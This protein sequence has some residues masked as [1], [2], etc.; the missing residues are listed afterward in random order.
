MLKMG[1][2]NTN[3]KN[4]DNKHTTKNTDPNQNHSHVV[5]STSTQLDKQTLMNLN[6]KCK[7]N[8]NKNSIG[9]E[10]E[11]ITRHS[12]PRTPVHK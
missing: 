2:F 11:F 10:S 6:Q 1:N 9:H 8:D 3:H 12:S 5:T 4:H 7:T